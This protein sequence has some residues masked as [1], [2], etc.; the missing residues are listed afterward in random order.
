MRDPANSN[1]TVEYRMILVTPEDRRPCV[2]EGI[3]G[4][5]H[6]PRVRVMRGQRIA[7]QL[8]RAFRTHLGLSIFVIDFS[9]ESRD[10]TCCAI[11]QFLS[12]NMGTSLSPLSWNALGS[13]DIAHEE[14]SWVEGVLSESF[15]RSVGSVG[16]IDEAKAWAQSVVG[17]GIALSHDIDQFNAGL[18]FSLVRFQSEDGRAYWLKAT[19]VPNVHEACITRLLRD[20][21]G[22]YV[23]TVLAIREDW[24]AWLMPDD[25]PTLLPA[26]DDAMPSLSFLRKAAESMAVLQMK[27]CGST[28]DLLRAGAFD[29]R[30]EALEYH[31]DDLFDYVESAMAQQTST[32]VAPLDG[33]RTGELRGMCASVVQRL[34]KLNLPD[35]IVHGDLNRGNILEQ[36]DHCQFL[37]WAEAYVG[38]P[39]I[40]FHNL[41]RLHNA[42]CD[43]RNGQESIQVLRSA[44][45]DAW[46]SACDPSF[47]D[48]GY[49]YAPM[50]TILSALY[51]R[52]DWLHA[53]DRD[54]PH[55]QSYARCLARHM[56]R[57]ARSPEFAEVICA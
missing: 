13:D 46:Q 29:Q 23:P 41:A 25:G 4:H 52:G 2:L 28:S 8:Q 55:R 17:E 49:A 33:A 30:L 5:H 45:R 21:C 19:G 47:I 27:T 9:S 3:D 51:G 50:L 38:C 48:Q 32:R 36:E 37:D 24:N 42:N 40:A 34:R 54:A 44:Y 43:A 15:P 39:L 10:G 31:L 6:L 11:A 56:D 16:W 1:E 14:R 22:G 18:G 7:E 57:A 26:S 20:L 12:P 53:P 35:A